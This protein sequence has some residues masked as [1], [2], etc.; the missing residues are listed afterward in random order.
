MNNE[1]NSCRVRQHSTTL[2]PIVL[3]EAYFPTLVFKHYYIAEGG[4]YF[5]GQ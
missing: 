5:D 4:K 2:K 3:L 1:K